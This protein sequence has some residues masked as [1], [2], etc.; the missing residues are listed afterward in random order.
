MLVPRDSAHYREFARLYQLARIQRP[1]AFDRWSGNLYA[2]RSLQWGSFDPPTGD[3]RMSE[4]LVLRHL[5]GSTSQDEPVRQAEALATVLHEAT[6]AGMQ[7]D[8]RDQPNA[9]R[10]LHSLGAM[11]GFAELRA[12]NDFEVFTVN[13]G[14]PGLR[15]GEPQYPGAYAAMNSLV[16]Q[17]SGPAKDRYAF[18]AEATG[19]PAA[20]HFDQ[21]ADGVVRNRLPDVVADREQ[22]RRAVRAVLI[23]AMLHPHWPTLHQ[24]STAAGELAAEDIR[25]SLNAKVD[26]ICRH[27]RAHPAQTFPADSPGPE[28]ART[29][30]PDAAR[31]LAPE[32]ARTLTPAI[33][34]AANR[35]PTPRPS[36]LAQSNDL[37]TV[38]PP[39]HVRRDRGT[40][41]T[42][43]TAR[44]ST[45]SA[46]DG[47]DVMRFLSGQAPAWEAASRRPSLGEGSRRDG[48]HSPGRWQPPKT[49][50]GP[51]DLGRD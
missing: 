39:D 49:R 48:L 32:A 35:D 12:M 29:L 41:A 27:Y 26:E 16:T 22:D 44:T 46:A 51:T 14:Y 38:A 47:L 13:A 36:A 15:P 34:S 10:T 19:G 8:A 3:L 25:L 11:E 28:A 5:T 37:G 23:Q 30:T 9:V 43:D 45:V 33:S 18:L 42:F 24:S 21:L 4:Q 7:T 1:T 50:H 2:T 31:T 20:M 17:V 6:H 40:S